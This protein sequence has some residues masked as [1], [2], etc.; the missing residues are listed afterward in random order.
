[1]AKNK[2][3]EFVGLPS[4]KQRRKDAKLN[5]VDFEPQYNGEKPYR[6]QNKDALKNQINEVKYK[7][8][9]RSKTS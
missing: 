7:E 3:S 5:G 2:T 6:A 4:R 1:M 8:K 9:R